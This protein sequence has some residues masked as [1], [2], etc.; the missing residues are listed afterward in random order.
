MKILWVKTDF[1]HPTNRGG[2]IRT[3]E[4][5]KRLHQRHVVDYVCFDE[6]GTTEGRARAGEYCRRVFTVPH[7]VPEKSLGSPAFLLQLVSGLFSS[8]PVAVQRWHSTEMRAEIVRLCDA[9]QYDSIVCD[10][11]FPAQ[12]LPDL[13]AAVLFQHN[14]EAQIWSRHAD[15]ASGPVRRAY[16]RLQAAR[17]NAYERAT[18]RAARRVVAVSAGDST[19]MSE[20]YGIRDIITVDTGVNTEFF[21]RPLAAQNTRAD[22]VFLGSMD[23][24]P[25]IDGVTWFVHEVLPIIHRSRPETTLAIVGR[26]PTSEIRSLAGPRINVTGTVADVREWLW[27]S[28]LSVVPLRI[29]GGTRLK[30]FEAM[31]AG[32]PVLSTPVGAEGLA[33]IDGE[34]L[35]I[36]TDP[37]EFADRCLQLLDSRQDRDR[38]AANGLRLVEAEYSWESVVDQFERALQ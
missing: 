32:V 22:L 10:F 11:L 35:A 37:Q 2:Q 29:G 33:V 5:L 28:A 30:I 18:C 8:V 24:L 31:A 38:L 13:S 14:V 7:H 1:L 27:G 34:H 26:S 23:W 16:F 12:N 4:M 17:M 36:A 20:R 19:I 25:N 3:L 9:E 21:R 15:H 6:V